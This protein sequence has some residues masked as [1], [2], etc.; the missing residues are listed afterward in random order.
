[1]QGFD[2]QT[3]SWLGEVEFV[4]CAGQVSFVGD[5]DKSANL[6]E[7]QI[8]SISIFYINIDDNSLA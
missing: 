6:G 5:S 4:R 7:F 8:S 1:L 3:D 2:L